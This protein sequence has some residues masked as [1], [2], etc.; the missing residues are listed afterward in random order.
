MKAVD[1]PRT[2]RASGLCFQC[3]QDKCRVL[4]ISQKHVDDNREDVVETNDEPGHDRVTLRQ[5]LANKA[6]HANSV[7]CIGSVATFSCSQENMRAEITARAAARIPFTSVSNSCHACATHP[8]AATLALSSLTELA[9][10]L[11][12]TAHDQN[13]LQ[14]RESCRKHRTSTTRCQGPSCCTLPTAD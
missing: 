13:F 5:Q 2:P 6:P 14:T 1:A 12:R 11:T 4:D 8:Q 3:L 7:L 10:T 9:L